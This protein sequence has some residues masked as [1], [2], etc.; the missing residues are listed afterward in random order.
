MHALLC[1]LG[2][3]SLGAPG[4]AE[5]F[6]VDR[7]RC[8]PLVSADQSCVV[9]IHWG[10]ASPRS[11]W[12]PD[13]QAIW[14]RRQPVSAFGEPALR[15]SWEDTLLHL[16]V[17]LP[18]FKVGV[19]ELADVFNLARELPLDWDLFAREVRRWGAEDAAWRVLTLA[20]RLARFRLPPERLLREWKASA[21]PFT[22]ADT[23]RRARLGHGLVATRSV[24]LAEIEKAIAVFQLSRR[25][26]ERVGALAR[27]WRLACWPRSAELARLLAE[28]PPP[29]WIGSLRARAR[30]GAC[31]W[32]AL[33]RDYGARELTAA[34]VAG[35]G[36]ALKAT[37]LRPLQG[38]GA[39]L[40]EHPHYRALQELE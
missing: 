40:R 39:P 27:T 32:R 38:K 15:M 10:L 35:I 3:A 16:C 6:A 5:E 17:R 14:A 29:G 8:S 34:T 37:A 2:Y 26:R 30:G 24:H 12:R 1:E 31:C 22:V 7:H 28:P 23:E 36:E 11:P 20:R 9:G 19:R 18:F 33:A 25:Y 13:P 21:R 4:A